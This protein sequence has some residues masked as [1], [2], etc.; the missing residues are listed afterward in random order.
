[1]T[2]FCIVGVVWHGA[3]YAARAVL[4]VAQKREAEHCPPVPSPMGEKSPE[5]KA[6]E[7]CLP[8]LQSF[9]SGGVVGLRSFAGKLQE[10]GFITKEAIDAIIDRQG[11]T[12]V[13]RAANLMKAVVSQVTLDEDYFHMLDDIFKS[14]DALISGHKKLNRSLGIIMECNYLPTLYCGS[15]EKQKDET[16]HFSSG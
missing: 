7:E 1:M 12:D 11:T 2:S 16:S 8:S 6:L 10:K 9:L 4:G 5:L 13:D 15:S 14:E 3:C